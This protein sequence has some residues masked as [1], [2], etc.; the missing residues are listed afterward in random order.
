MTA[1]AR[2]HRTTHTQA[3]YV[4]PSVIKEFRERYP[5]VQFNLLQGTS[6]QIAEMARTGRIDMAIA[7]G[8]ASL[9]DN[10]CCCPAIVVSRRSS[11]RAIIRWRT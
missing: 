10:S 1:P 6:E 11:C 2:F 7:T 8:P 4:L 5:K 3:R 9:F